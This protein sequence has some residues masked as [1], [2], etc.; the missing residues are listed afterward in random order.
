M[1]SFLT[2]LRNQWM[3]A[4]AL[5]LVLCGGTAYAANTIGSADVIDNSLRSVDLK[6]GSAVTGTDVT[7]DSLKGADVDESSLGKVPNADKLDGLNST[8]F[9][10]KP[11]RLDFFA[12]GCSTGDVAGCTRQFTLPDGSVWTATC[13]AGGIDGAALLQIDV[14]AA[15]D[16]RTN[17]SDVS[18]TEWTGDAHG[19]SISGD[20]HI[21]DLMGT[22]INAVGSAVSSSSGSQVS[23]TFHASAAGSQSNAGCTFE[24]TA[25]GS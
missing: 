15:S 24:G 20:G 25:I 8:A 21:Y 2:H 3:G 13:S 14:A 5:F 23:L 19:Y 11:V 16:V 10:R 22:T 12:Q 9:A 7:D 17:L 4:L 6:D 1:R 18:F